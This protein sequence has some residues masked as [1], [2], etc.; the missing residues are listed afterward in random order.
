MSRKRSSYRPRAAYAPPLLGIHLSPDVE[1]TELMAVEAFASGFANERHFNLLLDV[2]DK[3]LLASA[4][5]K[6]RGVEELCHAARMALENIK[7]RY[8]ECRRL[9]ATGE[10]LKAL[11]CLVEVNSDFWKRQGGGVFVAAEAALEQFR[12]HQRER[13]A[14]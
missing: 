6:E 14:A 2:A 11:R 5:K 1:I 10:E 8:L 12:K 3:L 4:H 13:A 9:G 7:A